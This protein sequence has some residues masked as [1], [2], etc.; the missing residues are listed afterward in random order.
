MPNINFEKLYQQGDNNGF[1]HLSR[2]LFTV[3][4]PFLTAVNIFNLF[5][6]RNSIPVVTDWLIF[7]LVLFV[8]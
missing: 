1:K 2:I 8:P 7:H 4:A 6:K 5:S 3:F